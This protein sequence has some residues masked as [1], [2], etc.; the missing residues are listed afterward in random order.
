MTDLLFTLQWTYIGLGTLL[1]FL[2]MGFYLVPYLIKVNRDGKK[3]LGPLKRMIPGGRV[4]LGAPTPAGS[5]DNTQ[6]T[7][8]NPAPGQPDAQ[9]DPYSPSAQR[10]GVPVKS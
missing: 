10:R 1:V 7:F 3:E 6:G 4:I 2:L 8:G 9:A 5:G